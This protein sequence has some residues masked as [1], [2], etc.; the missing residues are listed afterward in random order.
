VRWGRLI[1]AGLACAAA[2]SAC[3]SRGHPKAKTTATTVA[4]AQATPVPS[5]T[6]P[7]TTPATTPA[8]AAK[9]TSHHKAKA[10]PVHKAAPTPVR[11]APVV[12]T[13][14]PSAIPG[15]APNNPT[16]ITNPAL[17][18]PGPI[19]MVCLREAGLKHV[20]K[21]QEPGVDIGNVGTLPVTDPNGMVFV[22]G[23]YPSL[24][25]ATASAESL[26]G[27][28]YATR[29]GRFVVSA[30]LPSRLG[31]T[32]KRVALCLDQHSVA[33]GKLAPTGKPS[34]APGKSPT[35]QQSTGYTF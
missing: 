20:R 22:D 29:G 23:P 9:T 17:V 35:G 34:G 27:V 11:P 10:S 2:V 4:A 33:P 14:P 19:A 18:T 32:V 26:L 13:S 3:G 1:A 25:R 15:T 28:E 8:P 21:A 7:T 5:A 31:R 16:K 12:T 30:S 6:S 24:A